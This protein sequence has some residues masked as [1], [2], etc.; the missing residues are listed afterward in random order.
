MKPR[1]PLTILETTL[2]DG[3]YAINF[4]FTANDTEVIAGALE[5][6]GFEFIEI[7]HGVGLNATNCG[8]GIAAQTD[9]EY[10]EAAAR[11]LK[12]AKFGMFCIPGIARLEDVDMAAEYGMGFIRIGTDVTRMEES[13]TFIIRAKKHGMFVSSN[14]MKSYVMEPKKFAEKARLSRQFGS[15]LLC[16]VDS[17]GGMFPSELE[18]YFTAVRDACDIPLGFHGHANMGLA[19]ANTLR[20]IELGASFVDTSLQGLGRSSGNAATELVIAALARKKIDLGIDLLRVL[21]ISEKYIKPLITKSGIDSIDV[22]A[23]YCLFHSSF[24]G[25]IEKY[26]NKYK[27]DPRKLIM[28]VTRESK[29]NASKETVE[30]IAREISKITEK[31]FTAKFKLDKCYIVDEQSL[32]EKITRLQ[33]AIWTR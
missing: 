5:K 23:G 11:T 28:G 13:E 32:E 2:R 16:V 21:D 30:R 33:D 19:I 24:M 29:V 6:A 17:A 25:M 15:D 22:I 7:G 27:I 3:S 14:F 1:Q 12:N 20:A 18:S 8:A 10:L 26:S 9:Q 31:V 4:Q